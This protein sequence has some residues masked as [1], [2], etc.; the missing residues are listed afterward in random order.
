MTGT[1]SEEELKELVWKGLSEI[2]LVALYVAAEGT[3]EYATLAWSR[4][5]GYKPEEMPPGE[6]NALSVV[7]PDD[8]ERIAELARQRHA[9]EKAPTDLASFRVFRRDGSLAHLLGSSVPLKYKGKHVF[10]TALVDVTEQM[11]AREQLRQTLDATIHAMARVVET[12][13]PY[14][15]GH[16]KRVATLACAIAERMEISKE[17]AEGIQ[18]A[19]VIH[20]LGKLRVP[21]DILT[22]PGRLTDHEFGIIKTHPQVA[23]DILKGINFSWPVADIVFQ[24]HER[25][26]GSGYP[27][28][29]AG[30]GILLEARILGVADVV[31]AM[32]SHRPYRPA[33]GIETALDEIS[34]HVGS[35]Y[36]PEPAEACLEVFAGGAFSFEG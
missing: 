11:E 3:V 20:D 4:F 15:A 14:T 23:Y 1:F 2:D 9:G 5:F 19:G 13:D 22:N 16:Q 17:T 33:L 28:G 10:I 27:Q 26:D 36:A 25:F 6:F 30:E 34:S 31:E 24:H 32:A 21:A 8:R 35:R 7:H 29:L 18:M 12:R